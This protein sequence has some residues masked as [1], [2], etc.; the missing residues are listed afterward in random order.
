MTNE[1]KKDIDAMN[2]KNEPTTEDGADGC[3]VRRRGLRGG[4]G[5]GAAL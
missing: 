1:L 4:G 2:S 3:P 5:G